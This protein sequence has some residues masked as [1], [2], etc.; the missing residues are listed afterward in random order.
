MSRLR[1]PFGIKLMLSYCV[2]LMVPVLLIGKL[3]NDI[4]VESIRQQTGSTIQGTLSQMKSNIAFKLED[5][6]R[7]SDMLYFDE[8]LAR[9]LRANREGWESYDATQNILF[10]KF[11]TAVETANRRLWLSIYLKNEVFRETYN[12]YEGTD[13]LSTKSRLYD[14]YQYPRLVEKEWYRSYPR[15]EVYGTTMQWKQIED[16]AQYGRISLLRRLVDIGSM[17]YPHDEIGFMRISVS[18]K[19]LF[20]SVD[21]KKIG[22]GTTIYIYDSRQ[23]VMI[24]SGAGSIAED[25]A[26]LS[27]H[28]EA[29]IQGPE[30]KQG[31]LVIR[32]KLQGLNMELVAI[33][34]ENL[35]DQNT[36]KVRNLTLLI[37]LG[38]ILIILVLGTGLSRYFSRRVYKIV[39]VV[40]SFQQ[41]EFHKRI[42]FQG[43]DEFSKIAHA[44]NEMGA[45]VGRLIQEVYFS[46]LQKKQAEL[47]SLHAQI[48]PHFLYN[49]LSSISRLAKFGELDKLQ[50]MVLDLAKFYRLS[51]N[52]G[53]NMIPVQH[54][55]EQVQA[56]IDIQRIKYGE[57]LEVQYC[58][59][60]EVV[61]Y[62]TVKLI[63]QPFIENVLE[64]AWTGDR[65]YIRICGEV[66]KEGLQFNIIDDGVG[67]PPR[68]LSGPLSVDQLENAGY[69]IRNV[70]QRIRL[71]YGAPYGVTLYSRPGAGTNISI[72]IPLI[73]K[74][75]KTIR[76]KR[77]T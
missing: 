58:F 74:T 14:V 31:D 41:G 9:A 70:D 19:D 16:D 46:D 39:K 67:F 40:D 49:T 24:S 36:I 10:P 1:L 61:R 45:N 63:L 27:S 48:N 18:L 6:K 69:G 28:T 33:V 2:L 47:D 72:L 56:Y 17:Q 55:L 30:G 37:G 32:E 13:P 7:I 62:E 60:P 8:R 68:T 75:Q 29:Q 51:L 73:P 12:I 38:C 5:T 59:A 66:R 43:N 22:D 35:L 50:R 57:R 76:Q 54:E 4:Y 25:D 3:V 64:H 26:S 11:Q 20:D 34:P 44:L 42:H 65:I 53:R 23:G 15:D 52:E 77:L 21:F 71:H